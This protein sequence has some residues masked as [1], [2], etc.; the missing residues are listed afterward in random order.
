MFVYELS[1]C[2]LKSRCSQLNWHIYLPFCT[3]SNYLLLF[4][5]L[6]YLITRQLFDEIYRQR[7]KHFIECYCIL[8]VNVK[9][10][11]ITVISHRYRIDL[12]SQKSNLK[13]FRDIIFKSN[14]KNLY[15]KNSNESR[16]QFLSSYFDQCL[17][18]LILVSWFSDY[19]V[20]ISIF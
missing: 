15:F 5:I 9:L 1:G 8:V 4:L 7:N 11:F 16:L 20:C 18:I 2:G 12:N 19:Y 10:D 6:T 13:I 17:N 3:R 14:F